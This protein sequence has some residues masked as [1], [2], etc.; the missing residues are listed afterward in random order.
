MP[1]IRPEYNY[2]VPADWLRPVMTIR[3]PSHRVLFLVFVIIALVT[4]S[5]AVVFRVEEQK[6][7]AQNQNLLAEIRDL[8]STKG[9]AYP[10]SAGAA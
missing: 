10:R 6:L 3:L 4:S 2:R 1:T 5:L 7:A 8:Q 9:F